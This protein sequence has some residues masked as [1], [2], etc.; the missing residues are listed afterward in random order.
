MNLFP[1]I[2]VALVAISNLSNVF[3]LSSTAKFTYYNS[4]PACCPNSPNYDPKADTTECDDY[5]GCDYIGD[6]AAIGHKSLSYVQ[7]HNLIAFY[8]DADPSGSNFNN[9]YGGKNITVTKSCNGKT[10]TFACIIADTC[11]NGDCNNCCHRNSDKK[12]GFLIDMEYYTVL[13]NFG[14]TDCVNGDISFVI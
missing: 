11:G 2:F 1:F 9:K 3:A 12:T 13:N 6:F 5:S 8:D 7:S 4:Y 10:F 14:T